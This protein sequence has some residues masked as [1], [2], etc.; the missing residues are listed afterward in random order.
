MTSAA[1]LQCPAWL[2]P[3]PSGPPAGTGTI[4]SAC[5]VLSSTM[6]TGEAGETPEPTSAEVMLG[7]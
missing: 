3:A 5:G 1:T 6:N 7:A 4:I 2:W